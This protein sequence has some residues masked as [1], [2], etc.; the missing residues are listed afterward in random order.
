M[1]QV[2]ISQVDVLFSNGLYPIEFLFYYKQGFDT[3][4]IRETL[5]KLSSVFWPLFGEYK[6]GLISFDKYIERDCYDEEA[7]N[8]ELNIQENRENGFEVYSR[9]GLPD[10]KRLFFLKVIRLKSGLALIP[11]LNHLAGDGYS[12][13][14]FLS[15]LAALSRPTV[16]PF[17]SSLISLISKPHHR[18]T[19]LRDFSFQ[20]IG[21][22][23]ALQ[24]EKCAVEYN[25]IPR[26]AVQSIIQEAASSDKLRIS[27]NDILA[28]MAM[29]KLAARQSEFRGEEVH[30]TMPIDVRRQVKEYGRRFFGNGIMLHT[31]KLKREAIENL[32]V[33]ALAIK[34]RNAMPSVS[35][36]T[37]IKYLTQLEEFIAA[38]KTDKLRPFDPTRGVLVTNLSRL[39]SDKL[40]FGTGSPDLIV[41]L[42]VEKNSTAI[43]AK[44]ENFIIRYAY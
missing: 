9:F 33:K 21:L 29:K 20:R 38:G 10:L 25:E 40:N 32:T 30:L 24:S 12:Y 26:K 13:F 23:P 39:P 4:R 28:A 27:T 17:K 5:R 22:K 35:K 19:K 37:Y 18:R 3:K 16:V 43:L 34:I 1:K 36:E 15:L 7:V 44:K 41:P 8:Q 11:K 42:T 31:L 6:D 14:Y 2:K